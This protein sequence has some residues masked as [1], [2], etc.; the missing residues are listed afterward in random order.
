MLCETGAEAISW[1][2]N[3][4]SPSTWRRS[5]WVLCLTTSRRWLSIWTHTQRCGRIVLLVGSRQLVWAS[6][7]PIVAQG[8]IKAIWRLGAWDHWHL[9]EGLGL[10]V[11]YFMLLPLS[12]GLTLGLVI[13]VGPVMAQMARVLVEAG[14]GVAD[15]VGGILRV[16]R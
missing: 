1:V 5:Q 2:L 10:Q 12:A 16:I 4:T 15:A 13:A 6:K 9:T 11:R 14:R 7:I 8:W 3:I